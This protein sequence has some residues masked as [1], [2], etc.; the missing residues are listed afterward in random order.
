M[1]NKPRNK[2]AKEKDIKPEKEQTDST[3]SL[4][5]KCSISK[6]KRNN[7]NVDPKTEERTVYNPNART[8]HRGRIHQYAFLYTLVKAVVTVAYM[9]YQKYVSPYVLLYFAVQLFQFGVSA[10]YHTWEGKRETKAFLRK[11]DHL[12][13]FYLISGTQTAVLVTLPKKDPMYSMVTFLLCTWTLCFIGTI[14][15]FCI[16][17]LDKHNSFDLIVYCAQGLL[18]VVFYNLMKNIYLKDIVMLVLGGFF[19]LF[20]ALLYYLEAPNPIPNVFGFHE[21]FHVMTLLGNGC[22]G[23]TIMQ[24]YGKILGSMNIK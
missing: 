23:I 17:D 13:I 5:T 6:G 19:Y 4:K 10:M 15:L 11:L 21:I 20:G 9:F 14:K 12:A 24:S 2:V 22:F 8:R 16:T 3:S 1:P 18:S 7:E